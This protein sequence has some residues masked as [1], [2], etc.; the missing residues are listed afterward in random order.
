MRLRSIAMLALL[1]LSGA[2][3][4][5]ATEYYYCYVRDYNGNELR[6]YSGILSTA[7]EIDDQQTGFAYGDEIKALIARDYPGDGGSKQSCSSSSNLAYIKKEWSNLTKSYPGPNPQQVPFT[8]PP[9]PSTPVVESAP[10]PYLTIEERKPTGPTP[11]QV[12][13]QAQAQRQADA[14]KAAERART[15]ARAAQSDAKGQ[16]ELEKERERRRKCPRC[17]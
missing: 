5:L 11:E 1:A 3:D 17:Q 6:Y 16:A 2:G 8:N 9:V 4:A 15:A 10:G 14:A 7:G 12:A 13:A